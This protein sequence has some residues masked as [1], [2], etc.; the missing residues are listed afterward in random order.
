MRLYFPLS[1]CVQHNY[2]HRRLKDFFLSIFVAQIVGMIGQVVVKFVVVAVVATVVVVE[3][4]Y[5]K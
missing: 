1:H 5:C 4:K 3:N 2:S